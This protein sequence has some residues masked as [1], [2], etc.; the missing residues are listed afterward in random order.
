MTAGRRALT[1]KGLLM[2][3]YIYEVGNSKRIA[4][5]EKNLW[6]KFLVLAPSKSGNIL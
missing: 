4:D 2:N 5:S 6:L 1:I 3:D